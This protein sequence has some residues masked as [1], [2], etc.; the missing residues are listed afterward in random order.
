MIEINVIIKRILTFEPINDIPKSKFF[1]YK[2]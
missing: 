1:S 2:M